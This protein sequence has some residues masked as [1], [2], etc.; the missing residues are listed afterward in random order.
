MSP[1]GRRPVLYRFMCKYE[2]IVYRSMLSVFRL[3]G[4]MMMICCGKYEKRGIVE[5]VTRWRWFHKK[6]RSQFRYSS[7]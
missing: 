3:S 2:G 1:G 7:R 6:S 4:W 5:N